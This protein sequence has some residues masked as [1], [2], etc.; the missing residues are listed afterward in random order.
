MFYYADTNGELAVSDADGHTHGGIGLGCK[1]LLG[2][3]NI[4]IAFDGNRFQFKSLHTPPSTGADFSNPVVV[5]SPRNNDLASEVTASDSGFFITGL[6]PA[7]FWSALG[8]SAAH[9]KNN[10]FVEYDKLQNAST[11]PGYLT[12]RIIEQQ[13]PT[14]VAATQKMPFS[15]QIFSGDPPDNAGDSKP[16]FGKRDQIAI[17]DSVA[18]TAITADQP[19]LVDNTGYYLIE[20]TAN[21]DN[22][23]YDQKSRMSSVVAAVSKQYNSND[24]ITGFADSG[25]AYTHVGA[26]QILSSLRLRIL[27]PQTKELAG[28][29]GDNSTVILE[30]VKAQKKT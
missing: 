7:S 6:Q 19:Y 18:T 24:F 10:V 21:F 16:E 4:E 15:V 9:L 26:T 11:S 1:R 30:V 12:E 29:L 2:A 25:I 22:D 17:L 14:S 23:Y 27:E 28:G 13:V 20:A 5:T 3:R 8:F